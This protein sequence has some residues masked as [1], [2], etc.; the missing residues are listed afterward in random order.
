MPSSLNGVHWIYFPE[1]D[2]PFYR[3]TV[4]TNLSP[5]LAPNET[6]WSLLTETSESDVKPVKTENE[7]KFYY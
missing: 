2:Y 4:M 1:N 5:K 6:Y 7:L 3:V